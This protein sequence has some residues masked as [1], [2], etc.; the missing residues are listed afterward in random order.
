MNRIILLEVFLIF[1][2][3]NLF[4]QE[5]VTIDSL[6]YDLNNNGKPDTIYFYFN[7]PDK[8]EFSQ[9]KVITDS[10][11]SLIIKDNYD[12]IS[13]NL[14]EFN[15]SNS[16]FCSIVNLDCKTNYLIIMKESY[17][18]EANHITIIGFNSANNPI[19]CF[20]ST[21]NILE[22]K[23]LNNDGLD[24]LI[25]I[26]WFINP[27]DVNS[28]VQQYQPFFVYSVDPQSQLIILYQL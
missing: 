22:I 14:I 18:S 17:A 12:Q 13:D 26:K 5:S 6:F 27:I 4:S 25:G 16:K 10:L 11:D 20:D 8:I 3:C 9:L 21:F 1:S 28:I 15:L 7:T 2:L 24:E 19:I 23:D